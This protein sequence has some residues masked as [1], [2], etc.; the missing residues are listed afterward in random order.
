MAARTS[1]YLLTFVMLFTFNCKDREESYLNDG[2]FHFVLHTDPSSDCP[3]C[4]MN[5]MKILSKYISKNQKI[6]IY[7]KKSK[8]NERFKFFLKDS[9]KERELSFY[10]VDLKVPHPSILLVKGKSIYMHLY[11]PNDPFL[12]NEV[13]LLCRDFFLINLDQ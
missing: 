10:V 1:V 4:I 12:L 11:I 9:F 5:A 2:I 3:D 13:L 6:Y 8:D 7:L